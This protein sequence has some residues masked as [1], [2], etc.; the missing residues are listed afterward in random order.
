MVQHFPATKHRKVTITSLFNVRQGASESFREYM[1]QFNEETLKVS[2]PNK[3]MFVGA[4]QNGLK[5]YH[6]NESLAQKSAT[7]MKEVMNKLNVIPKGKKEILRKDYEMLKK[8][9]KLCMMDPSP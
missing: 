6:F 4:F 5:S 1:A 8:R 2:H 9:H 7:S 3:E